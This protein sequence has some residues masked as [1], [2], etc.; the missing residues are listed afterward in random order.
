M[1]PWEAFGHFSRHKLFD[2][3]RK[4]EISN[5][6][7]MS[8]DVHYAA[9]S[10]TP[11]L[12]FAGSHIIDVTSSGLMLS[13]AENFFYDFLYERTTPD[14]WY[15][16]RPHFD[17]NWASIEIT[18]DTE[19]NDLSTKLSVMNSHGQK[20]LEPHIVQE[21][22]RQFNIRKNQRKMCTVKD[23]LQWKYVEFMWEMKYT[24]E[25]KQIGYIVNDFWI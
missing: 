21:S 10:Q 25:L 8:G 2:L 11:C 9:M 5:V 3:V 13:W 6:N 4:H 15:L 1:D 22:E 12:S 16:Q 14:W 7:F 19:S 17:S 23:T 24:I 18:L 20:L